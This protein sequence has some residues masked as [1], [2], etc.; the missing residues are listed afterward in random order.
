MRTRSLKW[1]LFAATFVVMVSADAQTKKRTTKK[2]TTTSG[3]SSYGSQNNTNSGN[4]NQ[5]NSGSAYGNKADTTKKPNGG[6]SSYGNNYS[7]GSSFDTTL[8]IKVIK[9]TTGGLLDSTK[10]S[11]RNDAGVEQNLIRERAPLPYENI[12]ED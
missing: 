12:R 11:L 1:I 3:Y 9:N 5:G 2:K 7:S 8:P 4:G 10:M 6:G